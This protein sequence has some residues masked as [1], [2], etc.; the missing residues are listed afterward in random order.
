MLLTR[1]S[2]FLFVFILLQLPGRSFLLFLLLLSSLSSF[3][4][5]L[6]LKCTL[7]FLLLLPVLLVL[8][9]L[10]LVSLLL[11][12]GLLTRSLP[13]LELFSSLPLLLL[14][15]HLHGLLKR[16][17]SGLSDSLV[18]L[19]L[20]FLLDLDLL[21]L[22]D[23]VNL[24]LHPGFPLLALLLSLESDLLLLPLGLLES[25]LLLSSLLLEF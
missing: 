22:S 7:L 3:L 15:C 17:V 23:P 19:V 9:P 10:L 8:D 1:C 12:L 11:S 25:S 6:L 5:L 24:S 4:I 20:H 13:E 21:L 16:L 14:P 2:L 18:H